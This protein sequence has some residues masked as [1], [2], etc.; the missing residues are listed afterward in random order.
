MFQIYRYLLLLITPWYGFWKKHI[1]FQDSLHLPDVRYKCEVLFTKNRA[2]LIFV[3]AEIASK[4]NSDKMFVQIFD[5]DQ[6]YWMQNQPLEI[7]GKIESTFFLSLHGRLFLSSHE[8]GNFVLDIK[9]LSFIPF[10]DWIRKD[11]LINSKQFSI[12]KQKEKL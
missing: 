11:I 4:N 5:F 10:S 12:I 6:K 1:V 7:T 8:Y 9:N 3:L 2:K